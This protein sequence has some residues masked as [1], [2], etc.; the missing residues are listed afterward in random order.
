MNK[1]PLSFNEVDKL[2]DDVV[3]LRGCSQCAIKQK[4]D[5]LADAIEEMIP[6]LDGPYYPEKDAASDGLINAF[7]EYRGEL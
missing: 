3:F 2:L 6:Y 1:K 4:A 5:R 7:K